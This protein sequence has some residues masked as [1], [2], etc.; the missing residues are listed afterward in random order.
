MLVI[1]MNVRFEVL[2]FTNFFLA[3]FLFIDHDF[4]NIPGYSLP[5]VRFELTEF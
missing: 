2:D 4:P 3:S 1:I 5:K